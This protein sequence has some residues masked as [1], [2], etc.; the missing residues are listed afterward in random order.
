MGQLATCNSNKM[1]LKRLSKRE[2]QG[3]NSREALYQ[4]SQGMRFLKKM[5]P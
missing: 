4:L 5:N 2:P 3:G 1:C